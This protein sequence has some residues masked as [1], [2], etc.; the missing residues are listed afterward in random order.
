MD[1]TNFF[2]HKDNT[3]KDAIKQIDSTGKKIVF[4]VDEESRLLGTFTDG[5]MRRYYLNNGNLSDNVTKAMNSDPI[6]FT[7][8]NEAEAKEHIKQTE[9]ISIPIVD[10]NKKVIKA[11][12]WNNEKFGMRKRLIP[13]DIP[14]VIM[15]G[16]KGT[17]LYPYTKILPKPLIPIGDV[18]ITEHIINQFKEYGVNDFYMIINHKKNMIKSYFNEIEKDYNLN[19]IEE[20]KFLGTGGGLS[21]LKGKIN[22]TFFVSNCDILVKSDVEC[23]YNFHM[24]HKNKITIVCAMKNVTIPYGVIELSQNGK[25]DKM[26]EKPEYSFLTNTGV[27]IIEPEVLAEIKDDE[28]IDLP[29]IAK[30]CMAKGENVGVFPITEKSWLDMGQLDEM[31]NMIN[32]VRKEKNEI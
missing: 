1:I 18:P 21:L 22:S 9:L 15:A 25:I 14:V 20:E 19:Y 32:V 31:E 23:M 12:F 8:E 30:R 17:R 6:C 24:Q 3:I 11:F 7:C 10:E 27:Y 2:V 26:I 29:D 4:V 28:Y 16:G 5:D 13:K